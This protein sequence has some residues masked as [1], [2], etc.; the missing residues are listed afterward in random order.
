MTTWVKLG[1]TTLSA[2]SQTINFG[3]IPGTYRDLRLD[4]SLR[5]TS[6]SGNFS[7]IYL[8]FNANYSLVYGQIYLQ[9][10]NNSAFSGRSANNG[11]M[12][13]GA[14]NT[15]NTT[16]GTFSAWSIYIPN[17]AQTTFSKRA[18]IVSSSLTNTANYQIQQH[19]GYWANTSA[20]S[21]VTLD[22][23]SGSVLFAVGSTATLYGLSST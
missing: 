23:Y 17:Y 6:T 9:G 10:A 15:A 20:I 19:N 4:M 1:S 21:T 12:P 11:G 2:N 13:M 3:S 14:V 5:T 16:T 8:N 7:T 22:T 18:T